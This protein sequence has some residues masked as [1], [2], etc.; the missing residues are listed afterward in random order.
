M[1]KQNIFVSLSV[2]FMN[3]CQLTSQWMACFV[4]EYPVVLPVFS[5][6][7]Q[8]YLCI[9]LVSTTLQKHLSLPYYWSHLLVLLAEDLPFSIA[10]NFWILIYESSE[11]Y[12]LSA[13]DRSNCLIIICSHTV[14]K[15]FNVSCARNEREKTWAKSLFVPGILPPPQFI[16][17]RVKN[18][19]WP[20]VMSK[21]HPFSGRAVSLL[22]CSLQQQNE[23]IIAAPFATYYFICYFNI[24]EYDLYP[25]L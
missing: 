18:S 1:V 5:I 8:E 11:S 2:L 9:P 14:I 19:F 25:L 4:S 21:F 6:S 7:S 12:S 23:L 10:N 22:F 16:I 20:P 13:F 24:P 17:I 15:T 3:Q